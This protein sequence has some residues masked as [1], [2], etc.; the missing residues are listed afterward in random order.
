MLLT[1][2]VKPSTQIQV[3]NDFQTHFVDTGNFP[4]AA[5]FREFVLRINKSEP[6]EEFAIAYLEDSKKF[7]KDIVAYRGAVTNEVV[8]K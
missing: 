8:A 2:D 5:N 3:L 1:R 4:L 7:L 6:T